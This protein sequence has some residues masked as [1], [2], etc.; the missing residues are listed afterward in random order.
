[1]QAEIDKIKAE[2]QKEKKALDKKFSVKVKAVV[3]ISS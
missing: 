1:M 2:Y 3:D